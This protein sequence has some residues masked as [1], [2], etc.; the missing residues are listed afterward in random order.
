M[1][2]DLIGQMR[3]SA[4]TLKTAGPDAVCN[5]IA[6][7]IPTPGA[8]MALYDAMGIRFEDRPSTT[9]LM[10]SN[11][12]KPSGISIGAHSVIGRHCLLD[13]RSGLQIGRNVNISSYTLIVAGAHDFNDPDFAAHF[14]PITIEDYAWVA[15]RVTVLK[16]VTI[17]R[18]AVVA[19]G[20]V[21]TK[22]VEPMAICAGI[23]ARVVGQRTAEPTYQLGLPAV[24]RVTVVARGGGVRPRPRPAIGSAVVTGAGRGASLTGGASGERGLGRASRKTF[25]QAEATCVGSGPLV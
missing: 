13:G 22:D 23:P 19:A 5:E 20:A 21:V 25:F 1:Q 17:G 11:V 8:R 24:R 15:T 4:F 6:S 3:H 18:G 16:G 10:H 2:R 14:S 9:M 7:R 12:H